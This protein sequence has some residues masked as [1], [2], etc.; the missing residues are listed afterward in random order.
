MGPCRN[1]GLHPKPSNR[2]ARMRIAKS[3]CFV[4]LF[5]TLSMTVLAQVNGTGGVAVRV[6]STPTPTSSPLGNPAGMVADEVGLTG[7]CT[8][9]PGTTGASCSY[10]QSATGSCVAGQNTVTVQS[11][12]TVSSAL[13][14]K[15]ATL[16]MAFGINGSTSVVGAGGSENGQTWHGIISAVNGQ[17]LTLNPFPA[18]NSSSGTYSGP[19]TCQNSVSGAQLIIGTDNGPILRKWFGAGNNTLTIPAGQYLVDDAVNNMPANTSVTCAHGAVLINPGD[20]QF[21][22]PAVIDNQEFVTNA[23]TGRFNWNSSDG[24]PHGCTMLGTNTYGLVGL[25]SN[26]FPHVSNAQA[27]IYLG[28]GTGALVSGV[29]GGTIQNVDFINTWSDDPVSIDGASN[30]TVQDTV[31]M[32]GWAY[33]PSEI[34][35]P[36]ITFQNNSMINLCYDYEPNNSSQRAAAININYRNSSCVSNI[37][38]S[39]CNG[40][41][42]EC[43]NAGLGGEQA[44]TNGLTLVGAMIVFPPNGGACSSG[45][46]VTGTWLNVTKSPNASGSPL[47][48]CGVVC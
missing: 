40:G 10:T 6:V 39:V 27:Q 3:I 14:G 42:V 36:N 30:V 22:G 38:S 25:T 8:G 34:Y 4:L 12:I 29:T 1:G 46:P 31:S 13:I 44:F 21:Y 32:N 19:S 17:V 33:G 37:P 16:G 48:V 43:V 45:A 35:G 18:A 9:T 7:S 11:G 2:G 15:D 24:Q 20:E 28:Y 26:N 5:L 47:C 23:M 41:S